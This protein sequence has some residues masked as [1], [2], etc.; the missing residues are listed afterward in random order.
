MYPGYTWNM[1]LSHL[2]QKVDRAFQLFRRCQEQEARQYGSQYDE[3][4]RM[5]DEAPAPDP[6]TEAFNELI[7]AYMHYVSAGGDRDDLELGDYRQLVYS[8]QEELSRW[9]GEG[10]HS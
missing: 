4:K 9:E 10:G 3:V 1:D 5:E 6:C 2:Q 7:E 8:R